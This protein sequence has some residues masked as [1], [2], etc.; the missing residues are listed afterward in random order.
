MP[1]GN[2]KPNLKLKGLRV[3]RGLSPDELARLTGLTGP[4]IRLAEKG[5]VPLPR[6]QYAIAEFFEMAPL[7][8]WPIERQA[9]FA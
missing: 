4:T 3:N 2:R 9:V 7:D 6:T 5:H 8:I 1:Y